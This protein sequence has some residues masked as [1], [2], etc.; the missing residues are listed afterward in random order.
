M[1]LERIICY[2]A[3][4][5]LTP[6]VEMNSLSRARCHARRGTALCRLGM[7]Q[8]GIGELKAAVSL[9]PNDDKLRM[10]LEKACALVET[11]VVG[12]ELD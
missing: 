6:C 1:L 4:E 3:L 9:Q 8:Q 12:D 5:L 2:Q 11:S 7:M 10:D